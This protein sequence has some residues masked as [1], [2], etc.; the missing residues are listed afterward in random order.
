MNKCKV[1]TLAFQRSDNEQPH[2]HAFALT[3]SSGACHRWVEKE[4][5]WSWGWLLTFRKCRPTSCCGFF[6][7]VDTAGF[8]YFCS[9]KPGR[10]EVCLKCPYS[11]VSW[12]TLAVIC[13]IALYKTNYKVHI[14]TEK[15]I[16]IIT[17]YQEAATLHRKDKREDVLKKKGKIK[18][19]WQLPCARSIIQKP[20]KNSL[21]LS[22]SLFCFSTF[23]IFLNCLIISFPFLTWVSWKFFC[24]VEGK[25]RFRRKFVLSDTACGLSQ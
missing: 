15:Q 22:L 8:L 19:A 23:L 12:R 3:I 4:L 21:P 25:I 11:F 24:W 10:F 14:I 6:V 16:Y 20:C 13:K 9:W 7:V 17:N 2:A 5:H 18:H 1:F